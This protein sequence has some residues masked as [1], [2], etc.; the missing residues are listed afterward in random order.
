MAAVERGGPGVYNIVDD[1]PAALR[2]W[3]PVYAEALGA[4]RP[5]RVPKLLARLLAGRALVSI[6]TEARGAS[7]E[8]AKREL[9]WQPRHPTWRRGFPQS[10]R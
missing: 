8:R 1:D 7:N 4:P 2:E 3:L 10:L 6:A 5:L 9:E